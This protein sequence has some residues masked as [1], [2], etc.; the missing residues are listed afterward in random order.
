MR[1]RVHYRRPMLPMLRRLVRW[2]R[3]ALGG[4]VAVGLV[5]ALLVWFSSDHFRAFGGSPDVARLRASPEFAGGRFHNAEP[6]SLM[7]ARKWGG[8]LW[9]WF[10][11]DEMRAPVCP[12]PV[13]SDTAARLAAPPGSG[14]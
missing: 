8:A 1:G 13:V 10:F 9:H 4:A 3:Y 2:S 14:L 11:G 12:L 5:L 7:A 6:T